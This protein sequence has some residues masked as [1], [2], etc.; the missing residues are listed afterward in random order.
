MEDAQKIA[1]TESKMLR[2]Q[3]LSTLENTISAEMLQKPDFEA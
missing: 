1:E 3:S 2:L